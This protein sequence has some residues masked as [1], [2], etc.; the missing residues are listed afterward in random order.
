MKKED[1]INIPALCISKFTKEYYESFGGKI[2]E[3]GEG[4]GSDL[5]PIISSY[6]KE[7]KWL[8]LRAKLHSH[9]QYYIPACLF[10]FLRNQE[11]Y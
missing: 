11:Y 8:Y 5:V 3:V 1:Y 10:P 9:S 4:I 7:K 6:P 2:L